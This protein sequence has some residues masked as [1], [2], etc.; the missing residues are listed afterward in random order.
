MPEAVFFVIIFAAVA[1]FSVAEAKKT[2]RKNTNSAGKPAKA[3]PSTQSA[4][5]AA[6]ASA[7]SAPAAAPL[8]S[9]PFVKYEPGF[10]SLEGRAPETEWHD[11]AMSGEG[12]D[13]CHDEMFAV[14]AGDHEKPKPTEKTEEAREWAKAVVM[15]EILK[16]PSERRWGVR[17]R[18]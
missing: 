12:T 18:Q 4:P 6:P 11:A 14:F 17:G 9:A 8:Q 3:V 5:D 13:P 1:F 10:V 2:L 16:R 15:A 7:P